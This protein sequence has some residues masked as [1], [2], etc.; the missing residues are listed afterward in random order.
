MKSGS[1]GLMSME[2]NAPVRHGSLMIDQS[3]VTLD[4]VIALE[5]M[6]MNNFLLQAAARGIFSMH[7]VH[8]LTYQGVGQKLDSV[9][10]IAQAGDIE[11]PLL[12]SLSISGTQLELVGSASMGTVHIPLPGLGTIDDFSFDVDARLAL[13][14]DERA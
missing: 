6:R 14:R 13:R 2:A 12:L 11:V 10:G 3:G 1:L 8:D 7:R 5:K 4:L 9:T